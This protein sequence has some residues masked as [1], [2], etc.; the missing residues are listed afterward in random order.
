MSTTDPQTP[1]KPKYRTT[2]D[3]PLKRKK[4]PAENFCPAY[5]ITLPDGLIVGDAVMTGVAGRDTYPWDWTL[6]EGVESIHPRGDSQGVTATLNEA[7]D[8]IRS[9][10]PESTW[11]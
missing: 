7:I 5:R 11:G 3:Y 1:A 10:L 9:V 8:M 4:R 6:A 2:A